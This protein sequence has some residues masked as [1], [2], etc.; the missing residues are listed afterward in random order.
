MTSSCSKPVKNISCLECIAEVH[1]VKQDD[2]GCPTICKLRAS[3]GIG[4][5]PVDKI[6]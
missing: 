6:A 2:I 3:V 4:E 5:D 1:E